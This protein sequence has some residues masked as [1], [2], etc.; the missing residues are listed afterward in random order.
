MLGAFAVSMSH[1]PPSSYT[2]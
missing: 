1:L 2:M